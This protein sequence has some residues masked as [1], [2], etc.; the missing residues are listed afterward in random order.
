MSTYRKVPRAPLNVYLNKFVGNSVYMCRAA[1]ISEE[2]IFLA[3]LIEP[4]RSTTEVSVEFALPGDS[5]VMWAHGTIVRQG[6][7]RDCDATAVKFTV[8]PE[9]YRRRIAAYVQQFEFGRP[10]V[11]A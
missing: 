6:N 10:S 11:A 2:G 7:H 3:R 4:T 1:N 9:K 5:E 8:I